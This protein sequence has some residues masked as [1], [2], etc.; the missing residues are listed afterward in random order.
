MSHEYGTRAEVPHCCG[1]WLSNPA[2]DAGV[3]TATKRLYHSNTYFP[4]FCGKIKADAPYFEVSAFALQHPTGF[5]EFPDDFIFPCTLVAA[6]L[7]DTLD[8][9]P[10]VPVKTC[11]LAEPPKGSVFLKVHPSCQFHQQ[12]SC[13]FSCHVFTLSPRVISRPGS[14]CVVGLSLPP[15]GAVTVEV[16]EVKPC[17][18]K[19]PDARRIKDANPNLESVIPKNLVILACHI[20]PFSPGVIAAP[21]RLLIFQLS[22]LSTTLS[23]PFPKTTTSRC[24]QCGILSMVIY[25]PRFICLRIGLRLPSL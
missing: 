20:C 17:I 1:S 6:E 24:D 15:L 9:F 12:V 14:A 13:S 23:V 7:F 19:F 10:T 18:L 3:A 11:D 8:G 22:H 16:I 2:G 21:G 25:L 5:S 4:T